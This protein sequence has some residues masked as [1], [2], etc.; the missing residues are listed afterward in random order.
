MP[1]S[2]VTPVRLL[3]QDRPALEAHF[4]ALGPEDRRLRRM[5]LGRLGAFKSDVENPAG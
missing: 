4:L 5:C 2:P 3:E 1:Q